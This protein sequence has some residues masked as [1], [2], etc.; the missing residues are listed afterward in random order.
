MIE[1]S[2][3]P[4]PSWLSKVSPEF[5][6]CCPPVFQG[7]EPTDDDV[8]LAH[9]LFAALDPLSQSFYSRMPLFAHLPLAA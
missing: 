1:V 7:G 2:M 5:W 6:P 8:A 9:E 3:S 4:A